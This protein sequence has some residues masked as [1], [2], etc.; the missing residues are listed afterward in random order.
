MIK[1]PDFLKG[2]FVGLFILLIVVAS[3][4]YTENANACWCSPKPSS[5][6]S[7]SPTSE[8]T[9]EP[10]SEPTSEPTV[11][12]TSEPTGE[13]S[14]SPAP[15]PASS[16]PAR[17][18]T[19]PAGPPVCTDP[20]PNAPYLI[21]AT[22]TGVESI[23]IVW[24][25][26]ENANDY[27]IFYGPNPGEHVYGVPST[28]DTDRF[29]V[30]GLTSGCF[31]VRAVNGCAVSAPSNEVCTGG[32]AGAVLGASTLADT[33]AGE[34]YYNVLFIIGALVTSAGVRRTFAKNKE[35]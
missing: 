2:A 21:S 11:E 34:D 26:V 25:K 8:P 10:T 31:V 3:N 19:S 18:G 35:N 15:T 27:A 13:P 17:G 6:T 32:T 24:Q 16:E 22:R 28:G 23:E 14:A 1:L 5:S 9:A 29:T 4:S 30:N 12:P 20:A 33:G 7:P